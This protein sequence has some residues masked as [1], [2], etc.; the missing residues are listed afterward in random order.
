MSQKNQAKIALTFDLEYWHS[1]IYLKKYLPASVD[2]K[3]DN[4]QKT[5]ENILLILSELNIKATFFIVGKFIEENPWLIKKIHQQGHEIAIHG[6]DHKLITEITA[7]QFASDLEKCKK[8]LINLINQMPIGFRAPNFLC[9]EWLTQKLIENNF[10]YDSSV[11]PLI[12][13]LNKDILNEPY[14]CDKNLIEFPV[15]VYNFFG[16]KIP[17]SGGFYFRFF[18]FFIFNYFINK[19]LKKSGIATLYFHLMDLENFR[20]E[21]K[22]PSW[23]KI[24]KYWGVKNSFKKFEK[25]LKNNKN[26]FITLK[27]FYEKNFNNR[28]GI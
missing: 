1:G 6:Y 9:P 15:A 17:V 23:L 21:I 16:L 20:P 2:S 22:M 25:F 8:I 12:T 14:V 28:P 24:I 27:E 13:K 18:P 26:N 5:L 3:L 4:Y 7:D 10:K 11:F 19:I